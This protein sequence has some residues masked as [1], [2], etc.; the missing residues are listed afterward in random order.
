MQ[1]EFKTRYA[2]KLVGRLAIAA[3]VA[4]LIAAAAIWRGENMPIAS[5]VTSPAIAVRYAKLEP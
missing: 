4:A 2:F 1:R 3:A 5:L